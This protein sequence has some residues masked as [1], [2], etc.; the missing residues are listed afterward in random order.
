[1]MLDDRREAVELMQLYGKHF[2]KQVYAPI[3]S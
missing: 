3:P 2:L 1:M